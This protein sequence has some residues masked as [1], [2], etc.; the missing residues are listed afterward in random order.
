MD[1]L[2]RLI[3]IQNRATRSSKV[4]DYGNAAVPVKRSPRARASVPA[5]V[6]LESISMKRQRG[7]GHF[8]AVPS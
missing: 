4:L 2:V 3:E 5:M 8:I 6:E 1:I 7:Q